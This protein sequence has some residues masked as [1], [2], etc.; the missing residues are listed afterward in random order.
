MKFAKQF[1][2][3]QAFANRIRKNHQLKSSMYKILALL[4][5][6]FEKIIKELA[7]LATTPNNR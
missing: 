7:I 2:S 5:V 6:K 3:D 4:Q 1:N